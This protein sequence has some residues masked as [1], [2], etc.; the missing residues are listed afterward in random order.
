VTHLPDSSSNFRIRVD[1]YRNAK[2]KITWDLRTENC[3]VG[4]HKTKNGKWRAVI[5][6]VEEHCFNLSS[7]L[8]PPKIYVKQWKNIMLGPLKETQE[9]CNYQASIWAK[10]LKCRVISEL[11]IPLSHIDL[12]IVTLPLKL[13][14]EQFARLT[15]LRLP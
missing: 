7:P 2:K 10:Y 1:V 5:V 15:Q 12:T 9:Q 4:F 6:G 3:F 13:D 11:C 8:L 14:L